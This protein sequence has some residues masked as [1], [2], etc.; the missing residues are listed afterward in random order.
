MYISKVCYHTEV[1]VFL[2]KKFENNVLD[3][4]HSRLNF[5]LCFM[6]RLTAGACRCSDVTCFALLRNL[7]L[8]EISQMRHSETS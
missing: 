6:L 2:K 5:L 4:S 7:G 1:A 8:L 3:L